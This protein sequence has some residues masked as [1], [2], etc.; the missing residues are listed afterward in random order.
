[1]K[2]FRSRGQTLVL[3]SLTLLLLA[4]MV[5]LT[6][7]FGLRVRERMELQTIA[8]AA[9]YSEAVASAHTFNVMAVMNRTEWS[10]LVAQSAT[11]AYISW[12]SAYWGALNALKDNGYIWAQTEIPIICTAQAAAA[13]AELGLWQTAIN[14]EIA[15]IQGKWDPVDKAASGLVRNLNSIQ[16]V[17][18]D[19]DFS[20]NY[21]KLEDLMK[22]QNLAN[23]V[24]AQAQPLSPWKLSAPATAPEATNSREL[25]RDCKTGVAC[26]PMPPGAGSANGGDNSIMHQ[27]EIYMG[28]RGDAF[29]TGRAGGAMLITAKLNQILNAYGAAL[30]T[31]TGSSYRSDQFDGPQHGQEANPGAAQS[32]DDG[33]VSFVGTFG[34]CPIAIPPQNVQADVLANLHSNPDRH[35]WTG[36]VC[37]NVTDVSHTLI[38]DIA[39]GNWPIVIDYNTDKA[40]DAQD[41][42]GQPKM[43]AIIQR[44]YNGRID[45]QPEPYILNFKFKF[46]SSSNSKFDNRGTVVGGQS[47]M[48]T[49]AATGLAYYHRGGDWAEP[50]NFMNPFWRATLVVPD[51]DKTGKDD[52]ISSVGNADPV[53][54]QAAKALDS[55]GFKGWQ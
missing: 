5:T 16:A 41:I 28:S 50:P 11:Q 2:A 53:A 55:N 13:Q 34:G 25:S 51:I 52:V 47:M 7:S 26:D 43:F 19:S 33:S 39:G 24:I 29:T 44:D 18:Q 8:D 37:P 35:T 4:L 32:D 54:E 3:F 27:Y 23:E 49:A 40:Q 12:T 45:G 31:G 17:M 36:G 22:D 20:Q 46:T 48:Q 42:H 6:V 38:G 10:L 9:A 21:K 15:T 14:T 1:M 30:Y